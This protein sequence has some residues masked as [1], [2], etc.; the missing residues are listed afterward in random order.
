VGVGVQRPGPQGVEGGR[1]V[2]VDEG[3]QRKLAG[4]VR[5]HPR[6]ERQR[7]RGMVNALDHHPVLHGPQVEAPPRGARRHRGLDHAGGGGEVLRQVRGEGAGDVGDAGFEFEG[8]EALRG[9][10][11]EAVVG[12]A[13][14]GAAEGPGESG[15]GAA[16]DLL[17]EGRHQGGAEFA[18]VSGRGRARRGLRR[19]RR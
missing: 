19:R 2:A 18:P 16:V 4:E 3:A 9:G 11:D 15:D 10:V 17:F 7:R 14:P 12:E 5:R 13:R 1:R 8:C 6:H